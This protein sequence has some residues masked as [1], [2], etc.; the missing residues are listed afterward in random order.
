[1]PEV[2]LVGGSCAFQGMDRVVAETLQMPVRV[3]PH[4]LW[5][6]PL[7]IAATAGNGFELSKFEMERSHA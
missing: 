4:P 1:V 3:A 5:V 7:V 6:T 2:V